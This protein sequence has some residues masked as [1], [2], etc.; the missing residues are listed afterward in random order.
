MILT[1]SAGLLDK[2]PELLHVQV[3][4]ELHFHPSLYSQC[5]AAQVLLARSKAPPD[6]LSSEDLDP[7]PSAITE[8]PE[9]LVPLSPA[10]LIPTY[11][12]GPSTLSCALPNGQ[13]S[14]FYPS[15]PPSPP[16]PLPPTLQHALPTGQPSFSSLLSAPDPKLGTPNPPTSFLPCYKL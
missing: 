4:W 7:E 8:L 13:P 6:T 11:L 1:F 10:S 16:N 3:F 15:I 14:S 12:P 5:S 9:S 2:W